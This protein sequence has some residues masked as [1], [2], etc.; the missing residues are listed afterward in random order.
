MSPT[1]ARLLCVDDEPEVL[2]GLKLHLERVFDLATAGSGAEGLERIRT[3][4]PFAAVISDMRMP[5]MSGAEFLAQVRAAA[6][7]TVRLLLTGQSDMD[8]AVAAVNDGQ[9]FRF[10]TKPCPPTQ[11]RA[12]I[13]AAVEH[14]RLMTAE[15]ELLE[16]TLLGSVELLN[17]V[18]ALAHPE[19]F[20]GAI[21]IKQRARAVA[22]RLGITNLWE[23]ETAA[24]LSQIGYVTLE[25][26]TLA[27]M[28]RG[29]PLSVAEEKA[30]ACVP[31]VSVRLLSHVPRLEGVVAILSALGAH[32]KNAA[33][34][35][36]PFAA[37]LR[38]VLE[39]ERLERRGVPADEAFQTL[40]A[41]PT[42]YEPH[43]VAAFRLML[44]SA[45][46]EAEILQLGIAQVEVG[47]VLAEEVR[48]SSGMLL[49]GRGY[50]VTKAFVE[51]ALNFSR[52]TV[53]EPVR[54]FASQDDASRGTRAA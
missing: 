53:Q 15:R 35:A 29:A 34:A 50:V 16:Q 18:L 33:A 49:A 14:H 12:A 38:V 3:D 54:C 2:E 52:G 37:I 47:M 24:M 44:G 46:G 40:A 51:R 20:G 32:A 21:R 4:G 43:V 45:K 39:F 11:L 5:G 36:Q 10:L 9:I 7:Q 23:I 6:P 41:A 13:D 17:E 26:D 30:V 28:A 27:R 48:M 31:E 8:S 19:A 1:R 25:H 42:R 22:E